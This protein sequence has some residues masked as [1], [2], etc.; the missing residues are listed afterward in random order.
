MR[1]CN[2]LPRDELVKM[3]S[4][5]LL[6]DGAG[7]IVTVDTEAIEQPDEDI[8]AIGVRRNIEIGETVRREQRRS[9]SNKNGR[10]AVAQTGDYA[11]SI[12]NGKKE[13]DGTPFPRYFK[14]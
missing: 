10:I 14:E 9:S 3:E 4:V 2:N 5:E 7:I 6:K 13:C 11:G 12:Q 1:Q 8:P